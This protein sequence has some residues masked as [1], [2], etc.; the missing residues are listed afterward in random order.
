M[1]GRQPGCD[2][3]G[4][5]IAVLRPGTHRL[6]SRCDIQAMVPEIQGVCLKGVRQVQSHCMPAG[7]R[8]LVAVAVATR[9]PS[10]CMSSLLCMAE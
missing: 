1:V 7:E 5:V 3:Q 10:S 6:Q 4:T 9:K 8:E 2:V